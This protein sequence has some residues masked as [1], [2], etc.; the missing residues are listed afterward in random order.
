MIT[1]PKEKSQQALKKVVTSLIN[2]GVEVTL[3]LSSSIYLKLSTI[4]QGFLIDFSL[5]LNT[6]NILITRGGGSSGLPTGI[7]IYVTS[8]VV[9]NIGSLINMVFKRFGTV[10]NLIGFKIPSIPELSPSF[11][12]SLGIAITS[13]SV[14]FQFNFSISS[15]QC[16]Y[17][18]V[19]KKGACQF[20]NTFFTALIQGLTWVFKEATYLFDEAGKEIIRVGDI[21]GQFSEQTAKAAAKFADEIAKTS[22]VLAAQ[23]A[24]EVKTQAENAAKLAK[25]QA[26]IAAKEAAEEA[27]QIKAKA[28]AIAQQFANQAAQKAEAAAYWAKHLGETAIYNIGNIFSQG[29]NEVKNFFGGIF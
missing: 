24:N 28:E 13:D 5:D 21:I 16:F 11:E 3:V 6:T 7:Y 25:F 20:D 4:T 1:K 27:R 12:T 26:E 14:G 23:T 9:K 2:L 29:F 18:F 22:A 10:L 8:N 19:N 17:D 15:I